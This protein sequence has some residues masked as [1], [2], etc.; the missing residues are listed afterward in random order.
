MQAQ[1]KPL[2]LGKE[3][4]LL[5][6][7]AQGGMFFWNARPVEDSLSS[8]VKDHYKELNRGLKLGGALLVHFGEGFH[9]GAVYTKF[10]TAHATPDANWVIQLIDSAGNRISVPKYGSVA[11]DITVQFA[12][13]RGGRQFEVGDQ[14]DLG[15]S[16][17][18]GEA[19]FEEN[20][21][22]VDYPIRFE[23]K[24]LGMDI[25]VCGIY[26]MDMN[27]SASLRAS[28]FNSVVSE[29]LYSEPGRNI[30]QV[31]IP[32]PVALTNI[33]IAAS[34]RYTFVKKP[35]KKKERNL[36]PEIPR[37]G[38]TERFELH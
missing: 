3:E 25:A 36:K 18:V 5:S 33:S 15:I 38:D 13:I 23:G 28:L 37:K 1:V 10:T 32:E 22:Y 20:I 35:K 7:E 12:G 26:K 31:P 6:I 30:S 29:P 27:W 11:E 19:W 4:P 8:V 2:S 14:F 17:A 16:I 34:L 21:K 9:L 24:G